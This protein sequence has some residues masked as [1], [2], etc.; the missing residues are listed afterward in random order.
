MHRV[1]KYVEVSSGR[2]GYALTV[3]ALSK[4]SHG[5]KWEPDPS[6]TRRE[7]HW[8]SRVLRNDLH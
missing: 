2:V 1:Q 3:G 4:A 5:S 7:S 6:F 8:Q